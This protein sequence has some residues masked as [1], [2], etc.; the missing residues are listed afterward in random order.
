MTVTPTSNS[1]VTGQR[2]LIEAMALGKPVVA[3]TS[4]GP[5]EIVTD[6]VDGLLTPYGDARKLS[7]ALT[8]LLGDQEMASRLGR[9]AAR[10]A[11]D[12]SMA[13]Y[14]AGV[15]QAILDTRDTMQVGSDQPTTEALA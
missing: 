6:S 8:S 12:F 7:D 5:S 11:Q 13:T 1:S 15:T 3:S 4:G 9:Q 2:P 14:M 10:R